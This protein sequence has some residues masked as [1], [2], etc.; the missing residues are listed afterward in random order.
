MIAAL[1][2]NRVIG[3]GNK[4]PWHY[5]ADLKRFKKL[6]TGDTIIMGRLTWESLPRKPLPNR[7]NLVITSRSLDG[8][9]CFPTIAKALQASAG[10]IWFIGGARIFAEAM[11][12]VDTIDLTHVP[13]TITAPDAVFFPPIDSTLFSPGPKE[14]HENDPRLQIQRFTRKKPC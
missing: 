4:L 10:S 5:P 3:V 8:V 2:A 7:R 13:N 14:T 9:E 6:T 1:S 11:Q 12:W